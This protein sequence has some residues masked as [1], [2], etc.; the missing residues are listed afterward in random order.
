MA[1]ILVRCSLF[2]DIPHGVNL[3]LDIA[4][5][6]ADSNHCSVIT[7]VTSLVVLLFFLYLEFT[8]LLTKISRE[9]GN[10]EFQPWIKPCERHLYWSAT[11]TID[12]CGKVIYAKFR[13]FLSHII[14]KHT[15]LDDP[16]FNKCAHG[17]IPDRKW[18]DPGIVFSYFKQRNII[19]QTFFPKF[20]QQIL[21]KQ[22]TNNKK[23]TS[24][25][26]TS[27]YCYFI[28]ILENTVYEK[29]KKALSSDSLRKGIQ[30]ASPSAQTDCLEGFH[31]V[32]NQFA[33][34]I[35]AYS[36]L[37]MYCR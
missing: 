30:Q 10:E 5:S 19:V 33:P 26:E 24:F 18:I 6:F 20:P 29:V 36:Y 17:D 9:K 32:L 23:N 25:T 13:S 35:I 37:G 14:N 8:K 3:D 15:E 1:T 2:Q 27:A 22:N 7:D 28:L 16:L 34:K 31:S 11:S 12:G 4:F 21:N